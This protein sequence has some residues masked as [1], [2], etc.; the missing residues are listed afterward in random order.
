M[1]G[2]TNDE[3]SLTQ[4]AKLMVD[5]LKA[6]IEGVVNADRT[7][8]PK[9]TDGEKTEIAALTARIEYLRP[10]NQKLE[11]LLEAKDARQKYLDRNMTFAIIDGEDVD[12]LMQELVLLKPTLM[13]V[14]GA[15]T[16]ALSES[17]MA[18]QRILKIKENARAREVQSEQ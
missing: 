18:N 16:T 11:A 7:R 10:V 14:S 17:G 12:A 13:A 5:E 15:L 8:E 2:Q 9:L 4:K 3:A 1:S 6:K